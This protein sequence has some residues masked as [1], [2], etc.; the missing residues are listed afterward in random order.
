LIEPHFV[1]PLFQFLPIELKVWL[2]THF[3]MG[4]YG[5]I[6]DIKQAR[7]TVSSIRL[8]NKKDLL[9]L[10]PESKIWEEK[11]LFLTKSFIVFSN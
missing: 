10:F 1:F 8:L 11:I 7:E 5:K 6:S 9:N 3:S 4:W 2:I